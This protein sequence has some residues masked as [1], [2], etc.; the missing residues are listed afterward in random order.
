MT[1]RCRECGKVLTDE[2][3]DASEQKRNSRICKGCKLKQ[4]RRWREN[5]VDRVRENRTRHSRKQGCR[6]MC[7]NKE[8]SLFLG[9]Y[10]AEG[11]LEHVFNG[12]Q[13][14]PHGNKGFDFICNHNKMIDVK[15]SCLIDE[16]RWIF[17]INRNTT[18]DYFLCIAFD[19]R[20]DLNPMHIW[21]IPGDVVNHLKGLSI[22]QSTI[23]KWDEYKLDL[24]KVVSCCNEMKG[25]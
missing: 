11:V 18:A 7:E 22:H 24:D 9:V 2:N 1:E 23:H 12:V 6:S 3:W 16:R 8:C 20:E 10:V 17:N 19:N 15:S 25:E 5:N 14:M 4:S 21:L 13:A